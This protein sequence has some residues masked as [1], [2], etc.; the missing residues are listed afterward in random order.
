MQT[1]HEISPEKA[2]PND[3]VPIQDDPEK[4]E[5]SHADHPVDLKAGGAKS[6]GLAV[7]GQTHTI[8]T[9]GER[10]VTSKFEYWSYCA[11][12]ESSLIPLYAK[13]ALTI[14]PGFLRKSCVSVL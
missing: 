4:V 6:V 1:S 7:I 9:T 3:E 8:P 13:S 12:C 11:F 14:R 2:R 10:K 5:I